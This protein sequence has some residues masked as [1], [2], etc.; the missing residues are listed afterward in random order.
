[1]RMLEVRLVGPKTCRRYKLMREL[2]LGEAARA[3]VAIELI[4]DS[5]A[6]GILKY[7]TVNLPM[8]FIGGEKIA[9]GNPPARKK[10]QEHLCAGK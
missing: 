4:E 10:V 9:Q 6:E 7:R 5:E 3:S 1:M 2:V 8:L